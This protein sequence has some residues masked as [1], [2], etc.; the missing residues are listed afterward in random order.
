MVKFSRTNRKKSR[1]KL[2]KKCACTQRILDGWPRASTRARSEGDEGE[3]WRVAGNPLRSAIPLRAG[4]LIGGTGA[5]R[6]SSPLL[7]ATN[8]CQCRRLASHASLLETCVSCII[9]HVDY[10]PLPSH[11]SLDAH[12]RHASHACHHEYDQ[13][14]HG[15]PLDFHTYLRFAWSLHFFQGKSTDSISILWIP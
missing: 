8:T 12:A 1:T 4:F 14:F 6:L 5:S 11:A 7:N 15:N 9:R 13:Q 2:R 10:R 3:V